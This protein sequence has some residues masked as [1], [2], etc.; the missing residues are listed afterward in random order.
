MNM[1]IRFKFIHYRKYFDKYPENSVFK[2]VQGIKYMQIL[3]VKNAYCIAEILSFFFTI[4]A[5]S[6]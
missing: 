2:T 5:A 1:L 4:T 6:S 3:T